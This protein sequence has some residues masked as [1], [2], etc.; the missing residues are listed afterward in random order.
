MWAA[1][2]EQDYINASNEMLD[3]KW[4]EQTEKRAESLARI[5]RSLA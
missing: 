3:S 1:L 2:K 5:I 4:A